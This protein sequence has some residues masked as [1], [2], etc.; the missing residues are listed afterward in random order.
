[1]IESIPQCSKYVYGISDTPNPLDEI[2]KNIREKMIVAGELIAIDNGHN[3]GLPS[4]RSQNCIEGYARILGLSENREKAE[5]VG[6]TRLK[7]DP[8]SANNGILLDRINVERYMNWIY[9][10]AIW[11][12]C[13][14]MTEFEFFNSLSK[15]A[16]YQSWT[17]I[18]NK[19]VFRHLGRLTLYNGM[20][21][22]YIM[23]YENEKWMSSPLSPILSENK[24]ERRILLGL[25]KE[26]NNCINGTF[27]DKKSVMVLNLYCGLPLRE[28]RIMDT[29]CWPLKTIDD[30]YGYV[31]PRCVWNEIKIMLQDDLG[32]NL[33]EK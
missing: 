23:K 27:E 6:V 11:N 17:N 9:G 31:I 26:N 1:M 30:K 4:Y 29:F 20:H 10:N 22:Y 13:S 14:N 2:V 15:K 21:E 18:A 7:S 19:N 28:Q 33:K 12:E 32:I 25:R 16:P 24:E 8:A 5:F 3:F